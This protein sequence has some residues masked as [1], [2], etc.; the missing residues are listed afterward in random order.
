MFFTFSNMIK[1]ENLSTFLDWCFVLFVS[2]FI[3]A[4]ISTVPFGISAFI[5]SRPQTKGIKDAEF[6]LVALREKDGVKG[7]FYFLGAGVINDQQYYFWYIKNSDGSIS[8]G[9]TY[10]CPEVRI[11]EQ[12][13][14]PK[15]VTY[16]YEYKNKWIK[17]YLWI[18]GID[19]RN[20]EYYE[21]F[22][23]PK[24]SIK[25]GYNL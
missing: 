20:N 3:S 1:S 17:K 18:I 14:V 12:D 4:L 15:M 5:G 22:Y 11:Y 24:G 21:D 16:K 7:N 10:R 13:G 2:C 19:L 9:K 6:P 25:E 23:I 8:G